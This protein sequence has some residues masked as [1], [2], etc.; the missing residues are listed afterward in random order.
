MKT[1]FLLVLALSL[2]AFSQTGQLTG[3]I[4]LLDISPPGAPITFTGAVKYSE[5]AEGAEIVVQKRGSADGVNVSQRPI[6]AWA[7]DTV[8]NCCHD[9]PEGKHAIGDHFFRDH[10]MPEMALQVSAD[11]NDRFKTTEDG[12]VHD[13]EVDLLSPVNQVFTVELLF[14]QF[15]DGSTWGKPEVLAQL[16][17]D[18]AAVLGLFKSLSTSTDT[19]TL[20]ATLKA[21][22]PTERTNQVAIQLLQLQKTSGTAALVAKVQ[23]ALQSAAAR[24]RVKRPRD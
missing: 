1:T 5:W 8:V 2:S 6:V 7:A 12:I 3:T 20:L 15:D 9:G 17:A 14:V 22:Q 13:P 16:Q 11:G 10:P 23:N 21:P 4:N 19:N 24:P 18:R